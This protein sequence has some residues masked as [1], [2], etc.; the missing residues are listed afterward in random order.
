M[1]KGFRLSGDGFI[2]KWLIAG[3]V[4]RPFSVDEKMDDQ[5]AFERYMRTRVADSS[6]ARPPLGIGLGQPAF[7]DR[8]GIGSAHWRY[9]R[10][11]GDR[12]VDVSTFYSLPAKV[13]LYACADLISETERTA[14][15]VL[16]TYA[17]VD[18]WLNG[19]RIG[20]IDAPVYKPIRRLEL[21]LAL[22]KGENRLFARMQNLGVR[23]TRSLF[24]I[25]LTEGT[26]GL[27]VA[28]PD[29]G[30]T[31]PICRA[32]DWLAGLVYDGGCLEL[33]SP[34]PADFLVGPRGAAVAEGR[35]EPLRL[36]DAADPLITVSATI[37]GQ[38]LRRD[39]E[40][41]ENIK[42]RRMPEGASMAEHRRRI[43]ERLA[44][45]PSE[46]RGNG[47]FF[48]VYLALA[49]YSLGLETEADVAAIRQDLK[50]VRDRIDCSDFL[51]IGILRLALK[52]DL[53]EGLREEI[54]DSLLS[55]R[56]WMDEEGGDGMCFWSENHALMFYGAQMVA[57]RLYPDDIFRRSGRSGREQERIGELRCRQWL[58]DIEKDGFE[59][60]MSGNYM[61]VT[62]AALL[63][64]VDFGP[65]DIS[66]RASAV[67]DGI[68]ELLARHA[69]KGSVI[70]PQGRVYR[71]VIYPY[72]QDTQALLNYVDPDCFAV[73]CMW[74]SAFASSSYVPPDGIRSL[75]AEPIEAEYPQ[76]NATI[77]IKKTRDYL[78]TSATCDKPKA[79]PPVWR[80]VAA[81]PGADRGSYA[82][83]KS[84]NER[85]HG[86]TW[87]RP[88][89]FGYQQHLWYAALD[90][91]C[92]FFANHPGGACDKSSMRPGYWFGNGILPALRQE[93]SILGAI[94]DIPE[95]H[96]IA[97]THIY[98]PKTRFEATSKEGGWL[99]GKKGDSY[100]GLWCSA[101]LE[102]QDDLIFGCEYRA[103]GRKVAY[104]ATCSCEG[105]S[106]SFD[107][108]IERCSG[109]RPLFDAALD[110]L[111]IGE[112]YS[113]Q[114]ALGEDSTQ[115]I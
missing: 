87:L 42:P 112:A 66:K 74:M 54:K 18:L 77:V 79:L 70:S 38:E 106:G 102:A 44:A 22:R 8:P 31:D 95:S 33:P 63:H 7:E 5:L 6:L 49:R 23:D 59:E 65:E 2:P 35:S 34:A 104:A 71:S 30:A 83:V 48:S 56:Y 91:E 15:A 84:L 86:T 3:P 24:G 90:G 25:Q 45:I 108:F 76:G 115:Y 26:E 81:D 57:G 19:E 111:Q 62:A 39:I 101:E 92:V 98:W 50:Y 11:E 58:D 13:E 52:H 37:A 72:A 60:F 80:N 114:Y 109:L 43:I 64:L 73:D 61:I 78:L 14:R 85:F 41:A 20:G 93:G 12:F 4:V 99:F 97:F 32:D 40:L 46:P 100:G 67:M 9:R 94:Y 68:F 107:D 51:A 21:K 103:Y 55:Y 53:P 88:G 1:D 105:E 96:P 28:L 36:A 16:W 47:I 29:R 110:R 75:A 113:L 89:V 69:F 17:A 82:Y 27:S 10:G